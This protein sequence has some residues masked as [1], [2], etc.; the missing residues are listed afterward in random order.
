MNSTE[1]LSQKICVARVVYHFYPIIGGSA[2]HIQELSTKINSCLKDQIIIAL[3]FGD[4]CREFDE[5]FG[6]KI[7]R[8][9]VLSL[10][11]I[12]KMPVLPLIDLL[13]SISVYSTLKKWNA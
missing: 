2:T 11:F 4:S 1:Q 5:N 6:I 12:K 3:N 8:T 9:R 10:K 13:Y 7:I